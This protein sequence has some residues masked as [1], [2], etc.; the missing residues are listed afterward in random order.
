MP[1]PQF[2][3]PHKLESL[4]TD[5]QEL[6]E[7]TH[8]LN[9]LIEFT[10]KYR[11]FTLREL[12]DSTLREIYYDDLYRRHITPLI[13]QLRSQNS[14]DKN[15]EQKRD[16]LKTILDLMINNAEHN[17][18]WAVILLTEAYRKP[19]SWSLPYR[20]LFAE[21]SIHNMKSIN[22]GDNYLHRKK[23]II[24][25]MA[26][27]TK[28]QLE[29]NFYLEK[30]MPG[31]I[32]KYTPTRLAS[33]F[34]SLTASLWLTYEIGK[35][36]SLESQPYFS[37]ILF[38]VLLSIIILLT[39]TLLIL[40][41]AALRS[42]LTI[43]GLP[44]L[45]REGLLSEIYEYIDQKIDSYR[46]QLPLKVSYHPERP[47]LVTAA[48]IAPV[49]GVSTTFST[50][51]AK[52]TE[53]KTTKKKT[54]S[55]PH[56]SSTYLIN[57]ALNT[58]QLPKIYRWE[59]KYGEVTYQPGRVID[60]VVPLWSKF[61]GLFEKHVLFFPYKALKKEGDEGMINAFWET[62]CFGHVVGAQNQSGLV[63]VSEDEQRS[64][65]FPEGTK[66][67]VK[68]FRDGYARY[69]APVVSGMAKAVDGNMELLVVQS[70]VKTH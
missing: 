25:N 70:P 63:C 3:K 39:E 18:N 12:P 37:I 7:D 2:L 40:T 54:L 26:D 59:T 19:F 24:K 28:V 50:S 27:V 56:P 6:A 23:S 45:M 61:K 13:K 43:D 20:S 22:T 15:F 57:T 49:S 51:D 4:I 29:R 5:Y 66:L 58:T 53:T 55:Y 67:K 31:D 33:I 41:N 52:D 11:F 42:H 47:P 21:I 16:C 64:S 14:V 30:H 36:A 62:A 68:T 65:G 8:C 1:K 38:P 32:N 10:A 46:S 60:Y 35:K 34:I 48:N 9:Q 17:D 44:G 69:R